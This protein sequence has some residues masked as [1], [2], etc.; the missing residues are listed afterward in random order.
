MLLYELAFMLFHNDRDLGMVLIN[1]GWAE[2][3]PPWKQL[4]HNLLYTASF[5][6][7]FFHVFFPFDLFLFNIF[8]L[9]LVSVKMFGA[10]FHAFLSGQMES[11]KYLKAPSHT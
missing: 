10:T 8:V 4:L 2:K 9:Q 6:T 7:L 1:T 11:V 3:Y 5:A